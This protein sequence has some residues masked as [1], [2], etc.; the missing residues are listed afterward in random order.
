MTC[1]LLLDLNMTDK[2]VAFHVD[3]ESALKAL[4]ASVIKSRT[5][6]RTR[7]ILTDLGS[8]TPVHL[9]WVK[10]HVPKKSPLYCPGNEHADIAARKGSAS[11]RIQCFDMAAPR[12][13]MR[14]HIRALRDSEWK[15]EWQAR[16]DCRQTKLFID[17]PEPKIWAD[18]KALRHKEVS[19][20]VRFLTG[21]TYFN[22]H[23][24]VI[25]YKVR[26]QAAD[27]HEEATCRLCEEDEETP[28]HL[29]TTCP[30]LSQE[31][32]SLLCSP[33]L[34]TPPSWSRPLLDFL[35]LPQIRQLEVSDLE[36]AG[37]L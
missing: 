15:K 36:T 31:R 5:V 20:T 1:E 22:R 27:T 6:E 9:Q 8:R 11:N 10:A 29:V 2:P 28:A 35:N 37:G 26:G 4:D 17:G 21:H 34:D 18:I 33:E 16:T 19:A 7:D 24:V 25:K 23:N 13:D 12:T 30:A 14:N 3:S 32:F